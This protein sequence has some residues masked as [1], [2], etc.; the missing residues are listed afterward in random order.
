LLSVPAVAEQV[1]KDSFRSP[2]WHVRLGDEALV[3][4]RLDEAETA[5]REA[6]KRDPRYVPALKQLAQVLLRKKD[7]AGALASFGE[8]VRLDPKDSGARS[9]LGAALMAAGR[10]EEALPN[11]DEAIR[12]EPS[13]CRAL[14][15]RPV[16]L[17]ALNRPEA[18]D[19]WKHY[20]DVCAARP[21]E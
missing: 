16:A 21:E 12:L 18:R 8:I 9:N 6:L 3:A 20:L 13:N 11:F 10:T 17:E 5:Y 14:Y 19:G 4:G 15:N 2:P 1:R 7:A